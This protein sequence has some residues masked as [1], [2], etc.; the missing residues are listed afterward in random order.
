MSE[1]VHIVCPHC[2]NVTRMPGAHLEIRKE[3]IKFTVQNN[4]PTGGG[5]GQRLMAMA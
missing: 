2:P 4:L 3:D 5:S 1:P